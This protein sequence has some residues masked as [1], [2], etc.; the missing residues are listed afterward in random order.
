M[1]IKIGEF[2]IRIELIIGVILLWILLTGHLMTS[3]SRVSVSEGMRILGSELNYKMGEGVHGSWDTREQKKGSSLP[4]R[5]QDHDSYPSK[6][7]SPDD[8]LN[9]FSDTHFKPECCGSNYSS[10]G[11]LLK[12]GGYSSGGCACMSKK[13]INYINERGG[14]RTLTSVF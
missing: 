12:E 4:Y 6:F 7:V 3:C 13:Q 10:K 11:G 1:K 2:N 9:Y 14:N 5:S 8:S